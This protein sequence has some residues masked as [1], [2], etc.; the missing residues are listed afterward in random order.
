V[1][2][3]APSSYSDKL[4]P[5]GACFKAFPQGI[6]NLPPPNLPLA[7]PTKIPKIKRGQEENI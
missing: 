5:K 7:Y 6:F 1:K 4:K 2:Q 3:E